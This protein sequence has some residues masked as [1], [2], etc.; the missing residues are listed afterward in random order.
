MK[1][2]TILLEHECYAPENWK[3]NVILR[4]NANGDVEE[5]T[6]PDD[7]EVTDHVGDD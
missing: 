6:I 3:S 1:M 7:E 2:D 4:R 5:V